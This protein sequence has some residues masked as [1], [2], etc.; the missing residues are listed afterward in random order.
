MFCLIPKASPKLYAGCLNC[1]NCEG[2]LTTH[3]INPS[4][5]DRIYKQYYSCFFS[6][7]VG[8]YKTHL[9][10]CVPN[11]DQQS[12]DNKTGIVITLL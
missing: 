6:C 2:I 7:S 5:I 3:F 1:I 10:S 9:E 8:C 11:S 4:L 12:T